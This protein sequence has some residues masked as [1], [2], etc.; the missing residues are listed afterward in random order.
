LLKTSCLDVC[1]L[2]MCIV[3]RGRILG[4]N[5]DHVL[6][7]FLLAI[8]CHPY[9]F[10]FRFLF[11]QTHATSYSFYSYRT[12]PLVKEIRTKSSSLRTLKIM[13]RTETSAKLYVNEFGFCTS[14]KQFAIADMTSNK[15]ILSMHNLQ[16]F[17]GGASRSPSSNRELS[18]YSR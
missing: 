4:R 14:P 9:S 10:A 3:H 1:A 8:H 5:P 7:V 17:V 12:L 11:F 2:C 18:S 16:M 13:P 15:Q 6:R